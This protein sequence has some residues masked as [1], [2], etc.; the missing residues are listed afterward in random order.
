LS[1]REIVHQIHGI[2][3]VDDVHRLDVRRATLLHLTYVFFQPSKLSTY[4]CPV[5]VLAFD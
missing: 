5:D 2:A 1:E 4:R 3:K